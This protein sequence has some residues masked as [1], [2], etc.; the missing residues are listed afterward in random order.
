M[1]DL[2]TELRGRLRTPKTPPFPFRPPPA[3]D[4]PRPITITPY[5]SDRAKRTQERELVGLGKTEDAGGADQ[6]GQLTSSTEA[7]WGGRSHGSPGHGVALPAA[8]GGWALSGF[9]NVVYSL[10]EK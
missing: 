5:E 7:D 6:A 1:G 2:A 8:R 4:V 3:A 9:T 10:R